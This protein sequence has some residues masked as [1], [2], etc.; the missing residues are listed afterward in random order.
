MLVL[1]EWFAEQI[2]FSLLWGQVTDSRV[3]EAR[4]TQE[5]YT[6]LWVRPL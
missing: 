1:H 5:V 2:L 6:E 4:Q 3:E